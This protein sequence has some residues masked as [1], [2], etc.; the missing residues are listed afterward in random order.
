MATNRRRNKRIELNRDCAECR[1]TVPPFHRSTVPPFHRSTV[2]PFHRST[3]PPFSAGQSTDY[4]I[5]SLSSRLLCECP[6]F[7]CCALLSL[8]STPAARS[9]IVSPDR[10]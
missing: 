4:P 9:K 10:R 6:S 7:L 1:S 5:A 3:V 8:P 2:P